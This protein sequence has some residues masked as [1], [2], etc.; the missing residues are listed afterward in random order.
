[1]T[2]AKNNL[3]YSKANPIICLVQFRTI[4][5]IY[6]HQITSID[7]YNGQIFI[8]NEVKENFKFNWVFSWLVQWTSKEFLLNLVGLVLELL[9]HQFS[10]KIWV[11][12]K[13]I[14]CLKILLYSKENKNGKC[15]KEYIVIIVCCVACCVWLS[16]DMWHL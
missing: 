3:M 14:N 10:I 7:P 2:R 13:L 9:Q 16:S 4:N 8:T 5:N 6:M 15:R 12:L 11:I 1:M